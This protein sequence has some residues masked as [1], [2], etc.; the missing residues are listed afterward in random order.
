MKIGIDARQIL[1]NERGISNYIYALTKNLFEIDNANEYIL[2]VNTSYEYVMRKEKREKRLNEFSKYDNVVIKNINSENTFL[3]EQICLPF[4][5]LKDKIDILHMTSNRSPLFCNCKLINTVHDVIEFEEAQKN[6]YKLKSLKGKFYEWRIKQYIKFMYKNIFIRSNKV[7][8]ISKKSKEDIHKK[9]NIRSN[10]IH[11]IKHGI[12]KDFGNFHLRKKY[13]MT[14]GGTAIQKNV[15]GAIEAYSYLPKKI[16]KEYPLLI[17]GSDDIKKINLLVKKYNLQNVIIK[18]FVSK[19]ELIKFYNESI[20]FLFLSIKEGFGFPPMEAMACGTVPLVYN[21]NPMK[22]NVNNKDL[23]I[24][25]RNNKK[26]A[27]RIEQLINNRKKYNEL[28]S[29]GLRRSKEFSWSKCAKEHLDVYTRV[30]E[31]E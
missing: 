21:I 2:Y 11:I 5:V 14:F 1:I 15:E 29:F 20:I 26:I 9:L 30:Y 16:R 7:I 4:Y 13:I 23:Y 8:T 27:K 22:E 6:N 3:W 17:I 25:F 12:D 10:K 19:K 31:N 24:K 18:D 28:V